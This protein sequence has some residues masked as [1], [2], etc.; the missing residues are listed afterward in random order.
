MEELFCNDDTPHSLRYKYEDVLSRVDYRAYQQKIADVEAVVSLLPAGETIGKEYLQELDRFLN[1]PDA[2]L[3]V[4][5]TGWLQQEIEDEE[6]GEVT[7]S[8][9]LWFFDETLVFGGAY[10]EPTA[11]GT[12]IVYSFSTYNDENGISAEYSAPFEALY[13]LEEVSSEPVDW[14]DVTTE[15]YTWARQVTGSAHYEAANDA[16]RQELLDEVCREA[17]IELAQF[18]EVGEVM[19]VEAPYYYAISYATLDDQAKGVFEVDQASLPIDEQQPIVGVVKDVI[20][21]ELGQLECSGMAANSALVY[22]EGGP[23]LLIDGTQDATV[24]IVP[25]CSVATLDELS[26]I[27]E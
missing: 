25:L 4:R 12:K 20:Y 11:D 1:V 24:Y 3:D 23:C 16:T 6:S 17:K 5:F 9:P 14:A 18:M 2:G 13:R 22:G 15:L 10:F 8:E 26:L 19:S 21:P 27:G 7:Y